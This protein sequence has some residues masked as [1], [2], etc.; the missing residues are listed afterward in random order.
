MTLHQ[1]CVTLESELISD[2]LNMTTLAS[3]QKVLDETLHTLSSIQPIQAVTE[4]LTLQQLATELST[5]LASHSFIS[6]TLLA[7]LKRLVPDSDH[8]KCVAL[9]QFI[10]DSEYPKAQLILNSLCRPD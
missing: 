5:K 6:D 3:W 2:T 1:A 7:Q 8:E 9:T 4:T 10:V